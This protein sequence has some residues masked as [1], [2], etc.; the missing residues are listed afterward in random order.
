MID[1]LNS[2]K[3]RMLSDDDLPFVEV[4]EVPG[5][6]RIQLTLEEDVKE[7]SIEDDTPIISGLNLS[8]ILL[9]NFQKTFFSC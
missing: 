8:N 4:I 7:E 9:R 1:T 6:G 2:R 5:I 3:E